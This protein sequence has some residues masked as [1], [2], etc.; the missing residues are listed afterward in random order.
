[1]EGRGFYNVTL[2]FLQSILVSL[3]AYILIAISETDIV[4][5]TVLVLFFFYTLQP[6]TL[7]ATVRIFSNEVSMLS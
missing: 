2:A 7:V 3:L 1:M 6:F 4:L 5:N